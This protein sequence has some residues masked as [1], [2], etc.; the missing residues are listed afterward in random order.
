MKENAALKKWNLL[1]LLTTQ[2]VRETLT[3]SIGHYASI[4][5]LQLCLSWRLGCGGEVGQRSFYKSAVHAFLKFRK[6]QTVSCQWIC[7]PTLYARCASGKLESPCLCTWREN[8]SCLHNSNHQPIDKRE[9]EETNHSSDT[10]LFLICAASS[11][12]DPLSA[13]SSV[14]FP[15]MVIGA[16]S[17]RPQRLVSHMSDA[18]VINLNL[19]LLRH[20]WGFI[21]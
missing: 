21:W 19:N 16:G 13:T 2:L 8:Q 12:L 4:N 6:I 9:K 18:S 5:F 20:N 14:L 7:N 11:S 1:S 3:L 15:S 17:K 10:Q